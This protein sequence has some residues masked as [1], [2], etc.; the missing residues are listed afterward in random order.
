MSPWASRPLGSGSDAPDIWHPETD[1]YW[2]SE[3]EWLAP[4]DNPNSR[5]SGER[6]LD[7]PLAAVTMGLIYVN[8][9]GVDGQA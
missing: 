9:E 4:T 2:G 8:P 5:Y 7:N 6:D 3:K 1:I